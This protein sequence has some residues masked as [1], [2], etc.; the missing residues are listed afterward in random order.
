MDDFESGKERAN[1]GKKIEVYPA[2]RSPQRVAPITTLGQLSEATGIPAASLGN[3]QS[4]YGISFR[5]DP[6]VSDPMGKLYDAEKVLDFVRRNQP[7][8]NR[9]VKAVL[10]TDAADAETADLD[11]QQRK[12]RAQALAAERELSRLDGTLLDQ[13]LVVEVFGEIS[14]VLREYQRACQTELQTDG[15]RAFHLF[16]RFLDRAE[17]SIARLLGDEARQGEDGGDYAEG[18]E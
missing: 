16:Q 14:S 11:W 3:W 5:A 4:K 12:L 7:K 9:S 18:E 13:A 8:R 1:M 2:E 10:G 17:E 15:E 6:S